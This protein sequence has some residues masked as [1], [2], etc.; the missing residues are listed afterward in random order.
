M[1]TT[2]NQGTSTMLDLGSAGRARS[3]GQCP[4]ESEVWPHS[5]S[6]ESPARVQAETKEHSN[7]VYVEDHPF[8]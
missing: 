3:K 4:Q 6:E 2:G 5:S 7:Q 8:V 1:G